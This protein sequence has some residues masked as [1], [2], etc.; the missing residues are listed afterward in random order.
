MFFGKRV[1][2]VATLFFEVL[3]L[4]R[5]EVRMPI[6]ILYEGSRCCSLLIK[7]FCEALSWNPSRSKHPIRAA[8]WRSTTGRA[9]RG[10]SDRLEWEAAAAAIRFVLHTS[11]QWLS[12]AKNSGASIRRRHSHYKETF[13]KAWCFFWVS[14]D[15]VCRSLV[16]T[17]KE[18]FCRL[19]SR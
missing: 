5:H 2:H 3:I 13:R 7:M 18:T 17:L 8:P 14:S 12:D 16:L 6:P 19:R 1:L 10:P 15:I 11:Q 9:G 4:F